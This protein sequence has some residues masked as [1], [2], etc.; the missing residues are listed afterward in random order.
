MSHHRYCNRV[1]NRT[2][3]GR[4]SEKERA[5]MGGMRWEEKRRGER[6]INNRNREHEQEQ[7]RQGPVGTAA[8]WRGRR[9]TEAQHPGVEERTTGLPRRWKGR[10][11]SCGGDELGCHG[12]TEK[13]TGETQPQH[14]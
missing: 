9:R 14:P 1:G 6:E 12:A 3:V 8:E 5:E 7:K 11:G 13:S 10:P 4:G 2:E